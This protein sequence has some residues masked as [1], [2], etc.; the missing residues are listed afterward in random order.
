ML[1][2]AKNRRL[3]KF[4]WYAT[5]AYVLIWMRYARGTIGKITHEGRSASW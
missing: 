2:Q 1:P 4:W 5:G 3:R